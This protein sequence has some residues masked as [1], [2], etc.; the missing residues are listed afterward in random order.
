MTVHRHGVVPAVVDVCQMPDC[1]QPARWTLYP[2]LRVTLVPDA[3]VDREEVVVCDDCSRY[4]V[5]REVEF[6]GRLEWLGLAGAPLE[7]NGW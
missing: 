7:Q 6:L 2:I 1:G 3:R 4:V 5:A